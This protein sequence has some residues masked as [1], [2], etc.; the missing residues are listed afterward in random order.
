M[1]LAL[2]LVVSVACSHAKTAPATDVVPGVAVG[3]TAPSVS[4]TTP[5]G[6]TIAFDDVL[7][8]NAQTVVVFYRGFY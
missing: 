2:A 5:S 7:H 6:K 1:R 8:N 4:L 3:A